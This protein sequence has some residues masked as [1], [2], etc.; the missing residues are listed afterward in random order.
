MRHYSIEDGLSQSTV[1][2]VL[3]DDDGYI[4]LATWNGLDKFDGYSF[5]NYKSYPTD[6]VKLQHNRL[7]QIMKGSNRTIWCQTY[8]FKVYLFDIQR[9]RFDDVFLYHPEI[10]E[11]NYVKKMISLGNGA[12][13]IIGDDGSLWRIDEKKYR[14][15]GSV[16][17][18]ASKS[19]KIHGERVYG[20]ELDQFGNEWILTNRG[21]WVYDKLELY[22]ELPYRYTAKTEDAFFMATS[23]GELCT[24]TPDLGV[25]QVEVAHS[26][27]I[28]TD[29]CVLQD[30]QLAIG[31]GG[32]IVI[33]DYKEKV[34]REVVFDTKEEKIIRPR[35]IY[36][37]RNGIL[38]M[39]DDKER[40][41]RC[42]IVSGRTEI[43][44]FPASKR[45][46]YSFIHEDIHDNIWVLPTSGE[47]S[48]Y[49][50]ETKKFEQAYWYKEGKRICYK[51]PGRRFLIDSHKNIWL[52]DKSG[53]D[54]L[55]FS[56]D[57]YRYISSTDGGAG[58]RGLFV[59]SQ[60]RIWTSDKNGKI[61]I[62]DGDYNYLANLSL[63]G[64]LIDN[65][66]LV[67][68]SSIYCFFEDEEH[69]IWMGSREDGIYVAIPH[70][71][72]YQIK[73][74][75]HREKENY[76]ISN[77]S[78]Y[79]ICKDNSGRIWIG[80][81][82]GGLNLVEGIFPNL[83][84]IHK[85]NDLK[86]YPKQ[87]CEKVRTLCAAQNG[88]M[89]VGTTDGLLTFSD[90]FGSA[91][92]INFFH[93]KCDRFSP[94][95]LSNND[96]MYVFE[97]SSEEFYIAT[98]SG[99]INKIESSSLL[100]D[101]IEFSHLNKKNGLSSDMVYGMIEGHN[102]D[103]WIGLQDG[104]CKYNPKKQIFETYN[105]FGFHSNLLI[106]EA[107][108]VLDR[109]YRMHVGT[110]EGVLVVNTNHLKKSA[111]VPPI[112]FTGVD[113]KKNDISS[114]SISYLHDD[115]LVLKKGERN[116]TIKFSALDYTNSDKIEY[117]YRLLGMSDE[118]IYIDK[119]HSASFVNL[120]AGEF[121][122]EVKSTNGDGVWVD[123]STSLFLH[124]K[125]T[126]WE[127][128]WAILIYVLAILILLFSIAAILAYIFNLRRKVDFEQKLTN[129]KLRFFTDI[130]HELRTPLTLIAGPIEEVIEQEELSPV[131]YENM[132]IA[133][134]S[135]DRMLRLINQLLDFR[136]IQNNKMELHIE[137][138]DVVMLFREVYENFIPLAQQKEICYSFECS[139]QNHVVDADADK[140]EKILF[141]LLSNAF[142]YTSKG[143]IISVYLNFDSERLNFIVKDEGKGFD[144]KKRDM[145]FKRYETFNDDKTN[146][147]T[148]IGLSLVKE[149]INLMNGSIKLTS[150][151]GE[152]SLF[153]VSIPIKQEKGI[154]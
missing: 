26:T 37:A 74:F 79:S 84:F 77:N 83:K 125:P 73:R 128:G 149:L 147:S 99:G 134:R 28:L 31:R 5:K 109:R 36:Q 23:R 48:C 93:N 10:K 150:T 46:N 80:T 119:N 126:F 50:P 92:E 90:D 60:Q 146:L 78:I 154:S 65:K 81:H 13:W 12:L 68:G 9:E 47:L 140:L 98:F 100:S 15:K 117:S 82:G 130:S 33:Y 44:G 122:L 111:Y 137:S 105:N 95:S 43:I 69:R 120:P 132:I 63:S 144:P 66:Q 135:T 103:L 14:E 62:Y 24:Y 11:C 38:W 61:A 94:K 3:Q 91:D 39:F 35:N 16:E 76:S 86:T 153:E 17:Y 70:K 72:G 88:V 113:I 6:S 129:M 45:E 148:G 101:Q 118:W 136:K 121:Q 7:I 29:L 27:S 55:S 8:D 56:N 34:S 58:I 87:N 4:W 51:A 110:N 89:L 114:L 106:T 67:F 116:L 112:V 57:V 40:V 30:G 151:L 124:V 131:G 139:K 75:A 96:V 22:G 19:S 71:D 104:V 145:L 20:I 2:S 107:P 21:Y 32:G 54:K 25:Q 115:T 123:N 1:Q 102:G 49:N 141:N 108:P 42:D 97:T 127:T 59:D 138:V 64:R 18:F 85:G 142:K 52:C 143:K 53:L 133:K 152:G 41:V